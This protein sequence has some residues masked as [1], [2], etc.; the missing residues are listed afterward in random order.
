MEPLTSLQILGYVLQQFL[1]VWVGMLVIFALSIMTKNKTGLY[2]KLFDSPI[3]M[4][5]FALVLFWVLT[6]IFADTIMTHAALETASGMKFKAP[7]TP[8]RGAEAGDFQWYL[9]GGD[10]LARDVFSRMVAGSQI[11]LIIAP[12][13][14]LFAFMVGITLGLPAGY[15]GGRTDTVLSF[16]ANL[17]LFFQHVD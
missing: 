1:P 14:T 9:F 10:N 12:T 16:L 11:V 5:G 8:L 13:A 4:V 15:F 3:G 2:G 17:V 7:G 6:A